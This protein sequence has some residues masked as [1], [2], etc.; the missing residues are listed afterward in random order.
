MKPFNRA[1]RVA[2]LIQKA[3][4]QML[5]KDIKDPRLGAIVITGVKMTRDLKLARIYYTAMG[6]SSQK[7]KVEA[8]L[9][10]AGGFVKR[11]LAGR[12]GLRYMPEL[13]FFYDESIDYGDRIEK[14][15]KSI[16]LND[17]PDNISAEK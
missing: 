5:K 6:G 12:L 1:D 7:E 3:L 9:L 2:G 10:R 17:G 16:A 13:K 4:S 15:L 11:S 14:L 8:G